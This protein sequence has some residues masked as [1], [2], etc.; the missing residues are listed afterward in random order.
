MAMRKVEAFGNVGDDLLPGCH[1][2]F[3]HCVQCVAGAKGAQMVWCSCTL[4]KGRDY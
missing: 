4:G 1:L 3:T 2:T